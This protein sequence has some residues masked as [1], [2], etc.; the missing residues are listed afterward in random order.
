[1]AFISGA[2]FGPRTIPVFTC[3]S[4]VAQL[5]WVDRLTFAVGDA[6]NLRNRNFIHKAIELSY[7]QV[8]L[9]LQHPAISTLSIKSTGI[10]S[11]GKL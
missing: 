7:M 1:M 9:S 10:C 4:K 5:S 8:L 6:V 2:Q 3:G 11:N